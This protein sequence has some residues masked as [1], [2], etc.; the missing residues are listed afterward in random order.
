MESHHPTWPKRWRPP[1]PPVHQALPFLSAPF[2]RDLPGAGGLQA[3]GFCAA[4]TVESL[5][6]KSEEPGGGSGGSP[7]S[8]WPW[9]PSHSPRLPFTFWNLWALA[10]PCCLEA[11]LSPPAQADGRA[12]T[13]HCPCRSQS[14]I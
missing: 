5:V 9:G 8:G 11:D 6:P 2:Q 3:L 7:G 12:R 14:G 10:S 4:N 1:C 13:G